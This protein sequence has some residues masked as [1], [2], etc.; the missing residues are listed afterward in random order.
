MQSGSLGRCGRNGLISPG[1]HML[2]GRPKFEFKPL[3][4]PPP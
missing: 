3:A 2:F 4:I 1:I